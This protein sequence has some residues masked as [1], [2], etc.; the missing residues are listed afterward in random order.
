M[1]KRPLR[2][3]VD[4]S[5][6]QE[7]PRGHALYAHRLCEELGT[8][9]PDAEFYLY[10]PRPRNVD[11]WK[12]R[13]QVRSGATES[14]LSQVLWV[15]LALGKLCRQDSL[16]LFWS[17][18]VFLPRL[19]RS[20]KAIVTIYDFVNRLTP[21]SFSWLHSVAF[22]LFEKRDLHRADT[23][24]TISEGTAE[25]LHQF[26]G[27]RSLVIPPTLEPRFVPAPE[28]DIQSVRN[29]MQLSAPY[30]LNVAAWDPRKNVENLVKAFIQLKAEGKIPQHKLVLAGKKEHALP[31]LEQLISSSGQGDILVLGYVSD[32]HL[33]ALY[34]GADAFVFPSIYEGFGM[35]V[36][37][38]R[39]CGARVVTTDIS[40]LREAGDDACVYV[41]PTVP[42]I[43][44]GILKALAQ[45]R[46]VP[47]SRSI[48]SWHDQ[49]E[50]LAREMARLVA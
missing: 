17:P 33:P 49:A 24:T 10:S 6:F 3:G 5:L 20:T 11:G 37:E 29:N 12:G 40:E 13:W 48:P 42:G 4:G 35:P 9:L 43:S 26:L 25:K 2:I 27:Y 21:E 46:S 19:P 36:L 47:L 28:A 14:R 39:A 32:D 15:K 50:I 22:S 41:P 34:S 31:E 44:K 8:H 1:S 23:V 38:A 16:D 30:L 18:Y 7:Q 45:P